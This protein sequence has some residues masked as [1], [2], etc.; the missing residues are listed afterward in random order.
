MG[1]QNKYSSRSCQ[2]EK[3]IYKRIRPPTELEQTR[4]SPSSHALNKVQD[5]SLQEQIKW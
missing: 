4:R 5:N 3:V 1:K 2:T